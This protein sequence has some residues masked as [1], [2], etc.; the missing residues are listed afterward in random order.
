[1]PSKVLL[2][3]LVFISALCVSPLEAK[4]HTFHNRYHQDL[5][6]RQENGT[7][8][9]KPQVPEFDRPFPTHNA[10]ITVMASGSITNTRLT[11]P[12]TTPTSKSLSKFSI[13][14]IS[15]VD[16]SKDSLCINTVPFTSTP[17]CSTVLTGFFTKITVTDCSQ[18]VTFSKMESYA[19]ATATSS[20]STSSRLS[21]RA[22][23]QRSTLS[24]VA[25]TGTPTETSKPKLY[26]QKKV[27]YYISPWQAVAANEPKDVT[28][29]TCTYDENNLS[30][31]RSFDQVWVTYIKYV[32][33]TKTSTISVQTSFSEPAELAINPTLTIPVPAGPFDLSTELEYTTSEPVVTYSVKPRNSTT[34]INLR[35]TSTITRTKTLP[36]DNSTRT[37]TQTVSS[38]S[39]SEE[40]E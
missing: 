20:A 15:D 39:T 10:S 33:V 16:K 21:L 32:P 17:T 22:R 8:E 35:L 2:Q 5:N 14:A 4:S 31:C 1:M 25:P 3:F 19:V 18:S 26:L 40:P 27:T 37:F 7:T 28:V 9:Q 24:M 23:Q 29:V 6:L 11:T 13:C 12:T 30:K 38:A 34:T 36:S